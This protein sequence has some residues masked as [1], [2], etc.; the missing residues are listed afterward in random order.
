MLFINF[1]V[2]EKPQLPAWEAERLLKDKDDVPLE[3]LG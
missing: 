3:V 2:V 1:C